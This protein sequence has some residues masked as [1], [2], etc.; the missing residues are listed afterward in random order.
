VLELIHGFLCGPITPMTPSGNK[1]FILLVDDVS[2][3]M[4]VKALR[5]MDAAAEAIKLYHASAEAQTGRRLKV[6]RLDR[7]GEFNSEDFAKHCGEHGVRQQLTAPCNP[8]QNGVVEQRNQ[9][10]VGTAR[11]MMKSKGL[12]REFWA[13]AVATAVFVLNK[14][15]T[16]GVAGRTPYEVWHGKKTAVNHLRTFGCL[17]YVKNTS[18]NLKK[19]DD[20][21]RPMIFVGYEQGTIGYIVYDPVSR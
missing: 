10:M 11:S 15:P 1:Y 14:S 4:W 3:Y 7:G 9:T 2:Q 5:S 16:K 19:L 8:Q 18:P 17:A 13:E 6:F 12:P 20:R 21:S